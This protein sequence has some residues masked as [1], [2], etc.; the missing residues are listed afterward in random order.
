[1]WTSACIT[2]SLRKRRQTIGRRWGPC[3][4]GITYTWSYHHRWFL[5]EDHVSPCTDPLLALACE[6]EQKLNR[7]TLSPQANLGR[8][9]P[10]GLQNNYMLI[11]EWSVTKHVFDSST[12]SSNGRAAIFTRMRMGY[13]STKYDGRPISH[14]RNAP[15][16][17]INQYSVPSSNLLEAKLCWVKKI[18]KNAAKIKAESL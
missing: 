17:S 11:F 1:M 9:Q 7:H 8:P 16:H 6:I 2:S 12:Y 3:R 14:Q 15:W 18:W 13:I 4:L 10:A 5:S